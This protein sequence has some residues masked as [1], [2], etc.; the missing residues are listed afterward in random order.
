[1]P[2]AGV[3]LTRPTELE[4]ADPPEISASPGRQRQELL[5]MGMN[6]DDRWQG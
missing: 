5:V 2:I 4:R 1:M 3:D 6:G